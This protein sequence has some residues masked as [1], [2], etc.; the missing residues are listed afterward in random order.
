MLFEIY[1]KG[2]L[3]FK[4]VAFYF[5]TI[6]T[7]FIISHGDRIGNKKR[8]NTVRPYGVYRSCS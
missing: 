6:T 5:H 3:T 8:A 4:P 2:I 1:E 7:L